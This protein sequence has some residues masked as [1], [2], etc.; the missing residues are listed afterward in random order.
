M[1]RLAAV[2]IVGAAAAI[3]WAN[4]GNEGIAVQAIP[5]VLVIEQ[6]IPTGRSGTLQLKNIGTQ[7]VTITNFAS[8][9]CGAINATPTG[10]FPLTIPPNTMVPVMTICPSSVT[11][12]MP[13]C[14][15]HAQDM[16]H[17]DIVDFMVGLGD[18]WKL[19]PLLCLQYLSMLLLVLVYPFVIVD[20]VMNGKF[21]ELA[22]THVV[23]LAWSYPLWSLVFRHSRRPRQRAGRPA[24]SSS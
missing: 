14:L 21:L 6:P 2:A 7:P 8:S 10:G 1:R 24:V 23:F 16:A 4:G 22:T 9:G 17:T 12:G 20:H 15:F 3:A 13:R 18:A 5:S 11:P 19:H